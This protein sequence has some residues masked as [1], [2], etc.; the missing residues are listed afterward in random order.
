M[1]QKIVEIGT[2][3]S[4]IGRRV[5]ELLVCDNKSMHL[6]AKGKFGSDKDAE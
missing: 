1:T 4:S 5:L 2:K 3:S 6:A